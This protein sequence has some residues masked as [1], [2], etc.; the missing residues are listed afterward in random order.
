MATLGRNMWVVSL[1]KQKEKS[2]IKF[3]SDGLLVVFSFVLARVLGFILYTSKLTSVIFPALE[4][5]KIEL[6][7]GKFRRT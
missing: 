3:D 5:K 1:C 2:R 6:S 7:L 4:I